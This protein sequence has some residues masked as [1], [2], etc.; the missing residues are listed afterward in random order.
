MLQSGLIT[1]GPES[2]VRFNRLCAMLSF[3]LRNLSDRQFFIVLFI[4]LLMMSSPSREQSTSGKFASAIGVKDHNAFSDRRIMASESAGYN[5]EAALP[6]TRRWSAATARMWFSKQAWPLGFN[7]IPSTAINTTEMWQKETFDPTTIEREMHAAAAVGFNCARVFL[8]YLVWESDPEGLK[9]RMRTFMDIAARNHIKVIWVFF[10]DCTFI[11]VTD[12]HLGKQPDVISG[13]Y[14]N[15]WT[16]SPGEMRVV[17]QSSWP[18]LKIYVTDLVTTF[19]SDKRI[20]AWDLYNEPGN[21]HMTNKSLPLLKAVFT[22]ARGAGPSQPITSGVW[23]GELTDIN[24]VILKNSDIISFHNY[25]GPD[26]MNNEIDDLEREGRPL[27][28]TEWLARQTGSTVANILP[29]LYDRHVGGVIWGLVN[30]KTQTNYH[31]GSK[32][33]SP[34]PVL[35]QHDIFHGDLTYYDP[36]EIALFQR[37]AGMK[38]K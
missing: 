28:C 6:G 30:G 11:T 7:Y 36:N 2:P 35:W 38:R 24:D 3:A 25:G 17:N 13:E 18:G 1:G 34:A 21:S 16:P 27:I 19:R 26:A 23:R 20:F 14:A 33:G 8:Q 37:Y 22:W 15:G 29:I 12:P 9:A 32:A 10:D 4:A 5:I 31:W